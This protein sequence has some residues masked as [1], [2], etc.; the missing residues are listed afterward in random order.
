[1]HAKAL[2]QGVESICTFHIL[3]KQPMFG[4]LHVCAQIRVSSDSKQ[5]QAE[6]TLKTWK[7]DSA[8]QRPNLEILRT[9]LVCFHG[10]Q[11]DERCLEMLL[12]LGFSL[13]P[14]VTLVESVWNRGDQNYQEM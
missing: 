13:Y 5:K 9:I 14:K 10:M 2:L 4:C 3:C 8:L 7:T 6:E 11:I 1:M 12:S